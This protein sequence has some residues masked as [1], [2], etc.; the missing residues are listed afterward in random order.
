MMNLEHPLYIIFEQHLLNFQDANIDRRSFIEG[1]LFEYIQ[2]L[3]SNKVIV[4]R[5]HETAIFEEMAQQVN[6]MLIKKIYGCMSIKEFQEKIPAK[7]KKNAAHKY[8]LMKKVAEKATLKKSK[9]EPKSSPKR[10]RQ[11][12]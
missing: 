3:R 1:V 5:E 8:R 6:E 2:F 10:R 7:S 9:K 12:G 4:L 11:A